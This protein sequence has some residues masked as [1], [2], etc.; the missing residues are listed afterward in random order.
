MRISD[1]SSDVCSSDLVEPCPF[2][3]DL[4]HRCIG[5]QFDDAIMILA[6]LQFAGG[7]HHAAGFNAANGGNLQG[8]AGTRHISTGHTEDTHQPLTRIGGAADDL[9]R[10]LACRSEEHTSELQSLM[11]IS[12]AALCLKTKKK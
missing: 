6:Q 2:G 1:W 12:D 3:I 7:A 5:R 9:Q 8:D 4:P 10:S 11:R